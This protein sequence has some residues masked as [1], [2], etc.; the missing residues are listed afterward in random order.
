MPTRSTVTAPGTDDAIVE[1]PVHAAV[2]RATADLLDLLSDFFTDTDPATRTRLGCYLIDRYG[3]ENT[4]DSVTEAAIMLT[5]MSE[6]VDLLHALAGDTDT[7][8]DTD[9]DPY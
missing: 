2:L 6:A 4:T 1:V 8:T 7:D 9:T 3:Q 5:Q